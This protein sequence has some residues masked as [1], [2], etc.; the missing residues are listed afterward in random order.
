MTAAVSRPSWLGERPSAK[1]NSLGVG[2]DTMKY[3]QRLCH[4]TYATRHDDVHFLAYHDLHRLNILHLQNELAK[5]KGSCWAEEN[6]PEAK[7]GDLKDK[8]HD[9]SK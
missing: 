2:E 4:Y 1:T 6:V 3:G 8:L 5:L 7:L 9:Y